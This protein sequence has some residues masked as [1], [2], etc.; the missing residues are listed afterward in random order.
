MRDLAGGMHP[1]VGTARDRQ[2]DSLPQ[3]GPQRRF[4]HLLHG[5]A[6]RLAGPSGEVRAVVADVQ[7]DAVEPAIPVDG[8]LNSVLRVVPVHGGRQ[9][10]SSPPDSEDGGAK[11]AVS[12]SATVANHTS[13]AELS[14]E[15]LPGSW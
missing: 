14:Y 4:E 1:G 2:R 8:G 15:A 9:A 5:A 13:A 3:H 7:P 10:C 11:P 12:A 6:A